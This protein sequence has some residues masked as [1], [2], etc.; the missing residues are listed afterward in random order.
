MDKV[1]SYNTNRSIEDDQKNPPCYPAVYRFLMNP[2][3]TSPT[4][5]KVPNPYKMG[6]TTP[7]KSYSSNSSSTSVV[8]PKEVK[9]ENKRCPPP[10]LKP[11]MSRKRAGDDPSPKLHHTTIDLSMLDSSDEAS[12]VVSSPGGEVVDNDCAIITPTPAPKKAKNTNRP[13]PLHIIKQY[14]PLFFSYD[15]RGVK[16]GTPLPLGHCKYCRCPTIYCC[17]MILGKIAASH[18]EFLLCRNEGKNLK[19]ESTEGLKY[20][21]R[22]CYS[23][24]IRAKMRTNGIFF[25]FGMNIDIVYRLPLCV[26]NGTQ[27]QF[28]IML[29]EDK[30]AEDNNCYDM[31]PDEIKAFTKKYCD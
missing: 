11:A 12:V 29:E 10:V 21:F 22:E 9:K 24:A 23:E 17:D 30:E 5:K 1:A 31:T 25:P 4:N 20:T 26:K 13:L 19:D 3:T 28:L 27:R 15:P 2:F 6:L 14:H 7:K 18:T 16:K 8:L